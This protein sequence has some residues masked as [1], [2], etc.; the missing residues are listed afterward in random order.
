M[1]YPAKLALPATK[2]VKM[3]YLISVSNGHE[4]PVMAHTMISVLIEVA[5]H[6]T[7][8]LVIEDE[9]GTLVW[10]TVCM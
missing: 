6:M 4:A 3:F 1:L 2:G 9:A 5:S 10:D 8:F 7:G